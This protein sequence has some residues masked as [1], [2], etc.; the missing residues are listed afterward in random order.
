M[1]QITQAGGKGIRVS[2]YGVDIE[3][4][5]R[6]PRVE[7]CEER[8]RLRPAFRRCGGDQRLR[9]GFE[10]LRPRG[11]SRR[12][13][14]LDIAGKERDEVTAAQALVARIDH[15]AARSGSVRR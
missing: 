6:R 9:F 3:S 5:S 14:P 8:S 2:A 13:Q 11:T 7:P 1:L 10:S 4:C 12:Q 15:A